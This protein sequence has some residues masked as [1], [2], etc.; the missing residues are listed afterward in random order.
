LPGRSAF[1]HYVTD[2]LQAIY[3]LCTAILLLGT[4]YTA[5]FLK[6]P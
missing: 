4:V 2:E 1:L 6:E 5:F 3:P